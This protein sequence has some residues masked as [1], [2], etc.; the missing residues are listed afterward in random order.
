MTHVYTSL[1]VMS[2]SLFSEI[3]RSSAGSTFEGLA[4][5]LNGCYSTFGFINQITLPTMLRG[6]GANHMSITQNGTGN[7]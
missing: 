4:D 7:H 2:P 5:Q 1:T 6:E 3:N